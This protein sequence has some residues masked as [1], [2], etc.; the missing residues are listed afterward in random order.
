MAWNEPG[1]GNQDPW[2]G[3]NGGDNQGP[4][5]LDE[6]VRK[7]QEQIAGFFGG[8]ENKPS[9]R[10]SSGGDDGDQF[11]T[12][13]IGVVLGLA[14][15]V[16]LASGIY[17]VEP[18]ERGVV[19]R[20]GAYVDT[21]GP[22][23]HWHL[24]LPIESVAKVNVDEISTFSHRAA[25]LTQDE[26]IVEVE[27]T[28]QSRIQD[29]ADYLFQDQSPERTLNDATVTVVR[30][31]IGQSKLDYVMTEGRGAVAIT[32]KERIQ[33]LMDQYKTG[34]VVTSINMQ[35][36]KP[37]DQ[38][39]AAFDDAIKAREDKERLENQA[40][41]YSNEVLPQAR[42]GAARILA[43]AKAYRDRVVAESEGEASRFTAVLNQYAKA[44]EVTRQRLYLETMEQVLSGNNKILLDV[45]EGANS[46]LYLPVEQLMKQQKLQPVIEP[47]RPEPAATT[48]LM[49]PEHNDPSSRTVDRDRRAR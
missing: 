16:W 31:T 46:L 4:P 35:P 23:P 39:K 6:V 10:S 29:A 30:V 8:G 15:V 11:G 49:L 42:G 43:D 44:P 28:V 7:L 17:I 2:G 41:A 27:L 26:N 36:A 18:A 5:D 47:S 34:L 20:F 40:E 13:I 45:H 22:G 21:T 3:K 24:P 9:R 38:V 37:P 32:I 48:T 33:A 25:M 12:R 1:G 14:V 19:T